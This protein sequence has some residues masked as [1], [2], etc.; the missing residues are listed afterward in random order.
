MKS[1]LAF[2][3]A[4]T[5]AAACDRS[6][7]GPSPEAVAAADS[8]RS[9]GGRAFIG[10][11]EGSAARGVDAFGQPLVTEATVTRMKRYIRDQG[12]TFEFEAQLPYVVAR[13][14]VNH[15]LTVLVTRLR[16]HPNVDYVEPVLRGTYSGR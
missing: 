15:A 5:V 2:A 8:I 10:F 1:L 12:I 11:K 7:A 13:L 9:A 16:T 14:P 3:L 6:P 4:V